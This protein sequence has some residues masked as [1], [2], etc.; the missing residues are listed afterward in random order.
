ML[1]SVSPSVSLS[2][3]LFLALSLSL[4]RS[5]SLSVSVALRQS[6]SRPN[7]WRLRNTLVFNLTFGSWL[8]HG[9]TVALISNQP[10]TRVYNT[11]SEL[12]CI[13]GLLRILS[14]YWYHVQF[15]IIQSHIERL[16]S[17]SARENRAAMQHFNI[18]W[19]RMLFPNPNYKNENILK[20]CFFIRWFH[21][22]AC[23][24]MN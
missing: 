6:R 11:G 9:C 16:R 3:S 22:K 18:V 13:L 17:W 21:R 14:V 2:R 19:S 5:L 15:I 20:H 8:Q 23:V 10:R 4:A 1:Y 24:Q 7:F 12:H